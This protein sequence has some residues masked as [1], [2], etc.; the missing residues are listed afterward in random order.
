[1]KAGLCF[2]DFRRSNATEPERSEGEVVALRTN[3]KDSAAST[4][5]QV[6]HSR[7]SNATEPERSGG[8]VVAASP[9]D[10]SRPSCLHEGVRHFLISGE[11]TL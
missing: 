7:R 6:N 2:F 10:H 1:M 9:V 11:A 5:S 3:P 4:T 8:E